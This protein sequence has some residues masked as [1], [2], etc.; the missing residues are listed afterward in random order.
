MNP[1]SLERDRGPK[2]LILRTKKPVVVVTAVD[3]LATA[4]TPSWMREIIRKLPATD[5]GK[6][7]STTV[8]TLIAAL[9]TVKLPKKSALIISKWCVSSNK[10]RTRSQIDP[11]RECQAAPHQKRESRLGG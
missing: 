10:H 8:D 1:S 3:T 2:K 4:E 7:R 9:A 6:A 5:R 11:C